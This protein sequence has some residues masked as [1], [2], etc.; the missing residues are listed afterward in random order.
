MKTIIDEESAPLEEEGTIIGQQNWLK[1]PTL[2]CYHVFGIS[3]PEVCPILVIISTQ[4]LLQQ[5]LLQQ[6][7][8]FLFPPILTTYCANSASTVLCN[9]VN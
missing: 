5:T 1:R 2:L 3:P 4:T 8:V 7:F 6:V 9:K